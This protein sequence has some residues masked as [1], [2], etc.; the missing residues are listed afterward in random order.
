MFSTTIREPAALQIASKVDTQGKKITLQ[1]EG[2]EQYQVTLNDQS[3]TLNHIDK[4]S[5][6]L[7]EGLNII[8]V[9]TPLNCQGK[10]EE[11]V[12]IG[13]LSQLYPNPAQEVINLLIG[14]DSTQVEWGVFD[15]KGNRIEV[16][17]HQ[18]HSLH[19]N[20]P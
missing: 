9:K 13:A 12:Y 8:E 20:I 19:R 3:F 14:G 4:Q 7:K 17:Q 10:F 15:V 5:F 16:G 18:I 6:P 11:A 1:F 2:S